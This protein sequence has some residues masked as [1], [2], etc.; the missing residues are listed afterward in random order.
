MGYLDFFYK[1]LLLFHHTE[2]PG[3]ADLMQKM[4]EI[5]FVPSILINVVDTCLTE[6]EEIKDT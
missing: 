6:N 3:P 4:A 5:K 2:S 1:Y